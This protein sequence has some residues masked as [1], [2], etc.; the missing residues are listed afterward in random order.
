MTETLEEVRRKIDGAVEVDPEH[1]PTADAERRSP[2]PT[3]S[4]WR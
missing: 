3:C 1:G 2:I 4:S